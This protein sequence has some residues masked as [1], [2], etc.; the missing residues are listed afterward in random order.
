MGSSFSTPKNKK[1]DELIT[2]INSVIN[3]L[4]NKINNNNSALIEISKKNSLIEKRISNLGY[5]NELEL[6][7]LKK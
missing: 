1:Q 3:S 5:A 4:K 7:D 2:R 6:Q